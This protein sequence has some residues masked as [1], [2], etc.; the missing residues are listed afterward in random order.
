MLKILGDFNAGTAHATPGRYD[1][2][3]LSDPTDIAEA[4]DPDKHHSV[5]CHALTS[6]S[7]ETKTKT[8]QQALVDALKEK[9]LTTNGIT[10]WGGIYRDVKIDGCNYIAQSKLTQMVVKQNLDNL[11]SS[12]TTKQGIA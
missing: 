3:N 1:I 11:A 7:G 10:F 2:I 8:N 4:Y 9:G 6:P 5:I 12:A